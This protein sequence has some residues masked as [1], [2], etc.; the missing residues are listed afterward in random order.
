MD[1]KMFGISAKNDGF[2]TAGRQIMASMD[3]CG[4][5]VVKDADI[6]FTFSQ[7]HQFKQHGRY[8]IGYF[9]WESTMP[10]EGW[11][12]YLDGQDELW[13]TSPWQRDIV[14]G[15]GY[16]DVHVYEHG[17]NPIWEP[18]KRSVDTKV[19][20]LFMGL[21]ALRKGGIEAIR[22]FNL[23]FKGVDDVELVIKTQ[24]S[25]M[26]SPFPKIKFINE[27]MSLPELVQLY[28]DCHVFVAPT[29]GEGFG[30]PARDAAGTGMPVIATSG[31]LP[32]ENLLNPDLMVGSR[33]ID[34]PWPDIH[35]GQMYKPD[36]DD[37]VTRYQ[38]AYRTIDRQL[39][40]AYCFAPSIHKTYDWDRLTLKAFNRLALRI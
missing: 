39:N 33:L 25:Q 31:F 36:I 34:S 4:I 24:G 1:L 11:Q 27:D 7:P 12:K 19:R 40:D 23:A 17:I 38:W 26:T 20:F 9:P 21:E 14:Q 3:R 35:P 8:N 30:L 15:W 28:K 6:S 29:Y 2:G 5:N 37:L 22:A 16:S 13:V 32:Y 10:M 18:Q